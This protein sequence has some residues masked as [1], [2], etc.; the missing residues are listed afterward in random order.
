MSG[1]PCM[2]CNKPT[3]DEDGK[4]FAEVFVCS[5]C[6]TTA[7]RLYQ[8]LEGEL[9]RLLLLS[10][11][12]IRVAL[13]EGKLHAETASEQEIPKEDLLRMIVQFSERKE[14]DAQHP[15]PTRG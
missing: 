14:R 3:S 12:T 2:N 1:L 10:K 4:L 7:E 11:E 5:T 8:R 9:R 6:Y 13:I 15:R